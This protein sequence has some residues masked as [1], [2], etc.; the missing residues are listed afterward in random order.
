MSPCDSVS[1]LSLKILWN[2]VTPQ[3]CVYVTMTLQSA[4]FLSLWHV[5]RCERRQG[6]KREYYRHEGAAALLV[7]FFSPPMFSAGVRACCKV[8][9]LSCEQDVSTSCKK[10]SALGPSN[11]P[12]ERCA[13][14]VALE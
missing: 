14:G 3:R 6:A 10:G 8:L 4:V 9:G 11:V 13:A 5:V 1:R 12:F 7:D 2:D